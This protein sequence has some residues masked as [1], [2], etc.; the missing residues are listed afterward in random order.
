VREM[1]GEYE[2]EGV[3]EGNQV[4]RLKEPLPYPGGPVRVI[5]TQHCGTAGLHEQNR[6][7]LEALNRLLIEPDDL[8]A[9]QWR[10]LE[11]IIEE[12]PLRIRKGAPASAA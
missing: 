3:L 5:V 11:E 7:A 1:S 2:V 9:E 4:I 6:E 12:H 8:T 10:A